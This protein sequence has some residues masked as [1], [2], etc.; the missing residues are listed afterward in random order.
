MAEM[1]PFEGKVLKA[2]QELGASDENK[3]KSADH[4]QKKCGLPKSQVAAALISLAQK[5]FVKRI[6]R[7]KAS[8]YCYVK[9]Q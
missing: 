8:G 9:Q 1:T 4:V 7:E 2:L 6:V 3:L 5:G